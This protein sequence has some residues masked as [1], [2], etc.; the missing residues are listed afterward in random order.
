MQPTIN[1]VNTMPAATPTMKAMN[2]I[3]RLGAARSF[4]V[5][6]N[7]LFNLFASLSCRLSVMMFF[8]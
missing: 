5:S 3:L 6:F 8:E 4:A 7:S 1:R 2:V